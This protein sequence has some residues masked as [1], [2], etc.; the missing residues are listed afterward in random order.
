MHSGS[1]MS[2]ITAHCNYSTTIYFHLELCKLHINYSCVSS[3][4]FMLDSAPVYQLWCISFLYSTSSLVTIG[5]CQYSVTHCRLSSAGEYTHMYT[6]VAAGRLST[7]Y[8]LLYMYWFCIGQIGNF[9]THIKFHI[10]HLLYVICC[11][12]QHSEAVS[13]SCILGNYQTFVGVNYLISPLL[14]AL[15]S[16]ESSIPIMHIHVEGDCLNCWY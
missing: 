1:G 2:I 5:V 7:L 15:L 3:T 14:M 13:Y 10:I 12:F 11:C 4:H 8:V 9:I 16:I 6:S